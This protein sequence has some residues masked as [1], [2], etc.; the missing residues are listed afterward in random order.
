MGRFVFGICWFGLAVTASAA[1]LWIDV[2]SPDEY[3][4]GRFS[5]AINIPYLQ[6]AVRV[7]EILPDRNAE[8]IV[9]RTVGVRA[10]IA[11]IQLESVGYTKVEN[12]GGYA[13]LIARPVP[14]PRPHSTR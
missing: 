5:D 10:Q 8:V 4:S 2:R 3:A 11:K 13:N 14:N 9:Y 12:M 1:A 7:P 6:V